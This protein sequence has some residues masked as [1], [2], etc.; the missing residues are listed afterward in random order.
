MTTTEESTIE[1]LAKRDYPE[2]SRLA[3][4]ELDQYLVLRGGI[5]L[6]K[7]WISWPDDYLDAHTGETHS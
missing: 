6:E 1:Q 7:F 2:P 3:G 5:G 4:H